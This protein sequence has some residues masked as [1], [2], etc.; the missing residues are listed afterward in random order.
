M[1]SRRVTQTRK[2]RQGDIT[3]LCNP[4]EAWSPRPIDNA[5]ADLETK[6]HTYYVDRDGHRTNVHV[7]K[8]PGG[9]YLRT[10]GDSGSTNNLDNLP[11]G[12]AEQMWHERKGLAQEKLKSD[13]KFMTRLLVD[14]RATLAEE[15]L[16]YIRA[17]SRV[18]PPPLPEENA[19]FFAMVDS[20]TALRTWDSLTRRAFDESDS[21]N[22]AQIAGLR[23]RLGPGGFT[24][25]DG[26][27][28]DNAKDIVAQVLRN[29][30]EWL[31]RLGV[32]PSVD[33]NP[34]LFPPFADVDAAAFAEWISMTLANEPQELRP[35]R[36]ADLHTLSDRIAHDPDLLFRWLTN[37]SAT[38][39][40]V[41][42]KATARDMARLPSPL[43]EDE[44][45]RIIASRAPGPASTTERPPHNSSDLV[46]G[47]S[48]EVLNKLLNVYF[49]TLAQESERLPKT[50]RADLPTN[51]PPPVDMVHCEFTLDQPGDLRIL[52]AVAGRLA[53]TSSGSG[54]IAL[55]GQQRTFSLVLTPIYTVLLQDA[56]VYLRI[57]NVD[58]VLTVNGTPELGVSA[59]I[60]TAIEREIQRAFPN[61]DAYLLDQNPIKITLP[62]ADVEVTLDTIGVYD[63]LDPSDSGE[64]FFGITVDKKEY[65]FGEFAAESRSN[66]QLGQRF[67][68]H[69]EG[70]AF[71]VQIRG[72]DL[73]LGFWPD[74]DDD[75][76]SAM[77]VHS[78]SAPGSYT[79]E[80]I[81]PVVSIELVWDIVATL[82]KVFCWLVQVLIAIFNFLCSWSGLKIVWNCTSWRE[83]VMGWL[84]TAHTTMTHTYTL[85]YQ[86]TALEPMSLA[87][88]F[89]GW[90]LFQNGLNDGLYLTC[91]VVIP[92]IPEGAG[93][94]KTAALGFTGSSDVGIALSENLLDKI[95]R[96]V[97]RYSS[98]SRMI[99]SGY[100][101]RGYYCHLELDHPQVSL[102]PGVMSLALASSGTAGINFGFIEQ[103]YL[104]P[105]GCLASISP[106]VSPEGL[107]FTIDHI[108]FAG[109]SWISWLG[110]M[111]DAWG[112][113]FPIPPV[114]LTLPESVGADV[115]GELL[116]LHPSATV[117]VNDE[118]LLLRFSVDI[119]PV[120]VV[121]QR[122]LDFGFEGLKTVIV[123]NP[124]NAMLRINDL[125]IDNSVFSFAD[126]WPSSIVIVPQKSIAVRVLIDPAWTGD[127]TGRLTIVS[128]D[129]A[130]PRLTILIRAHDCPL[131]SVLPERVAFSDLVSRNATIAIRNI[132]HTPL[133]VS[134]VS[135]DN[136]A[137]A[138]LHSPTTY[139]SIDP[140][141]NYLLDLECT[142]ATSQTGSLTIE[143]DDPITGPVTVPLTLSLPLPLGGILEPS[144]GTFGGFY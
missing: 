71:D 68:L 42:P 143:A 140:G 103:A 91:D 52:D 32:V 62:L 21:R 97:W 1:A 79:L 99:T 53:A 48:M 20:D 107:V 122:T 109:P 26:S 47:V 96:A 80:G 117:Q 67:L 25:K 78:A 18:M 131:I 58:V 106:S 105:D 73:D 3:A 36:K 84:R 35:D 93:R 85:H 17:A 116:V 108:N 88:S 133:T 5:I 137:F 128:N 115:N 51:Q 141:S 56:K 94:T 12:E 139:P 40:E 27:L 7:V 104:V 57:L 74:Q 69:K 101:T 136:D 120:L 8:G 129:P 4:F 31:Q 126:S 125:S 6:A 50:F 16:P 39:R 95:L 110:N 13:V 66:I 10:A 19:T 100:D 135:I 121:S 15:R 9:K 14:A 127:Q 72:V 112:Y 70:A 28:T 90:R 38:L 24:A 81:T 33:E 83:N 114:V 138:I 111:L 123:S 98:V 43:S 54:F 44:A 102:K 89:P 63:D 41:Y 144:G 119:A 29:P 92:G 60:Q 130:Q 37:P 134:R 2:N 22:D 87:V 34:F 113:S 45:R 118:D 55:G 65:L 59:D 75:L 132:G 64:L 86:V 46:V 30:R 82:L 11:S 49:T 77:S 142:A 76:G 23:Q 124:G 61:G